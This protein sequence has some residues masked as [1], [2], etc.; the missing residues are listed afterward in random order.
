MLV[1]VLSATRAGR[2]LVAEIPTA[3]RVGASVERAAHV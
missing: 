3:L 2:T 1:R